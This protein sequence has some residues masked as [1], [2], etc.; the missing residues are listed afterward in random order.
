M[1]GLTDLKALYKQVQREQISYWSDLAKTLQSVYEELI[2]E[3]GLDQQMPM[4][5]HQGAVNE[6]GHFER[7]TSANLPRD[8][9]SIH[10]ALQ[11]VLSTEESINPPNLLVTQW[12]IKGVRDGFSLTGEDGR[13]TVYDDPASAAKSILKAFEYKLSKFSPYLE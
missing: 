9:R 6:S 13:E 3:L 8:K 1:R 7:K 12:S 11:V 10:F 2:A 5:L 4:G